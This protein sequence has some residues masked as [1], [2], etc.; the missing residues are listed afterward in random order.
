MQKYNKKQRNNFFTNL[1]IILILAASLYYF[2][3]KQEQGTLEINSLD[4]TLSIY[5]DN[6]QKEA[7]TDI[8]PQFKIK[9]GEHTIV[10]HKVD[11][12]PWSKEILIAAQER[13]LVNPFFVPQ[14]T[15]GFIIQKE[16]SEY[17]KILALFQ[18]QLISEEALTK[19]SNI[20]I[21]NAITALDFYKNREDVIL[22]SLA[23]GVYAL[24]IDYETEQNLQPIYKGDTPL[25]VKK[26]NDSIYVL[27]NGNLMEV[28]Y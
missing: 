5:I 7:T 4:Q 11:Y 15:S 27:D 16:D 28:S 12:W 22:M 10:A 25:F 2:F 26:D 8:N 24:G 18:N 23:D 3:Y 6:I 13:T 19:I 9:A 20:E 1:L 17:Y 21:K 14:N